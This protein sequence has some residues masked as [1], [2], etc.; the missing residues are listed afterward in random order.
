MLDD[1]L[2]HIDKRLTR[3]TAA[4]V[5]V[6]KGKNLTRHNEAEQTEPQ[7]RSKQTQTQSQQMQGYNERG[8]GKAR[9]TKIEEIHG[10]L[11]A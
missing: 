3:L 2:K 7:L 10:S 4:P 11:P 9:R 8:K 1:L 6:A 5:G